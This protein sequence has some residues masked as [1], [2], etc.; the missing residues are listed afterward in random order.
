ML[1]I[2]DTQFRDSARK[3][4]GQIQ[5]I[6]KYWKVSKSFLY[7]FSSVKQTLL[8]I[9]MFPRLLTICYTG[10]MVK[11]ASM[12]KSACEKKFQRAA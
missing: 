3:P 5:I 7:L 12:S 2:V 9:H 1:L 8:Y 10:H 4:L 6:A 11:L